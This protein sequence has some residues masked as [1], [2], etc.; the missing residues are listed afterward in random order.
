V[1]FVDSELPFQ[2]P[3]R[4]AGGPGSGR[5]SRERHMLLAATMP[6]FFLGCR[7]LE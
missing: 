6:F 5:V 3:A 7:T 2:S 1:N 4:M